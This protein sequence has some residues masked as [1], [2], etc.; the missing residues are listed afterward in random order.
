MERRTFL[1][2][3]LAAPLAVLAA[4]KAASATTYAPLPSFRHGDMLAAKTLQDL[5]DA[6]AHLQRKVG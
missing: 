3:I 4:Y 6:V 5:A 1:K 2:T